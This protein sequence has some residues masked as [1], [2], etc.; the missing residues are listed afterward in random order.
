MAGEQPQAA[1][2][3]RLTPGTHCTLHNIG[4]AWQTATAF[5][6]YVTAVHGSVFDVWYLKNRK[7][8]SNK[9]Y[10]NLEVPLDINKRTLRVARHVLREVGRDEARGKNGS[11]A[12]E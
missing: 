3:R 12:A 8:K 10:M 1:S 5:S 11:G 6:L 7:K 4:S 2:A 9:W